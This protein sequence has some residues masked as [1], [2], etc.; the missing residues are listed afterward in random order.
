MTFIEKIRYLANADFTVSSC[1]K[2]EKELYHAARAFLLSD[3][4]EAEKIAKQLFKIATN[5]DIKNI[6]T[7]LILNLYTWQGRFDELAEYGIPRSP[8]EAVA[9]ALYNV[10]N[11]TA[12]LTSKTD[13]LELIHSKVGWAIAVVNINGVDVELMIDTGAGITVINE[14]TAKKCGISSNEAIESQDALGNK[15]SIPGAM[16]DKISIGESEFC[17]KM[18]MVIPDN[19]IDFGEVK[20]NG[21]IGW[22]LICQL[23]WEINFKENK[24]YVTAPK[25]ENVLRNM[26]Y[27]FFPLVRTTVNGQQVSLG[28]DTGATAT[29]FG[30]IMKDSFGNIKQTSIKSG[31]AGGYREE[32]AFIIPKIELSFDETEIYME[33]I[34]VSVEHECSKSGIF[35]TPGILGIDI[36]KGRTLTIDYHNRHLA[37][38]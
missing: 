18:C 3:E 9:I 17:N 33:N 20:I 16:I 2:E 15:M 21:T 8:E 23:K 27:D 22:E 12:K 14:T 28:L 34:S 38:K 1:D 31:G 6:A 10:K 36:A 24:A 37:I 35:I 26:A 32:E 25:K 13:C 5:A 19:A 30:A 7:S 29:K 4:A 11:T